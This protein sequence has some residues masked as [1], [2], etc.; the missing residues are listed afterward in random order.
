MWQTYTK[1]LLIFSKKVDGKKLWVSID[2]TS[3][4]EQ[5]YVACFVFGIL[6]EEEERTKCYLGNMAQLESVNHSTIAAFFNDS[7]TVLWPNQVLY[8]NVFIVAT[9]A[10]PYMCKA[11][12][13]LQVLFPKMVHNMFSTWLAQGG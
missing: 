3:D 8:N 10:A 5:R 12:K 4:C 7:L 6:G 1:K 13:G 11:M 9:D 2:E